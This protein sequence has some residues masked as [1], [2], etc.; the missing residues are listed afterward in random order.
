MD[1]ARLELKIR[2]PSAEFGECVIYRLGK[3]NH[4]RQLFK[5]GLSVKAVRISCV[6]RGACEDATVRRVQVQEPDW[7]LVNAE[8]D[9]KERLPCAIFC[10]FSLVLCP[11]ISEAI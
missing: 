3:P 2:A 9:A 11:L 1:F 4:S 5:L 10:L 7:A 6:Y 8:N